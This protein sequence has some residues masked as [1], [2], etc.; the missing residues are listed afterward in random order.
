VIRISF[1]D[2]HIEIVLDGAGGGTIHTNLKDL[3]AAEDGDDDAIEYNLGI[4]GLESLLLAHACA[5]VNVEDP[6]YLA[7]IEAAIEAVYNQTAG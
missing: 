7:G 3:E 1:D 6:K 2:H 4:D 5:G